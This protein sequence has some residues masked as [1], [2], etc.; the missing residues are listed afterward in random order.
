MVMSFK[1]QFDC[2]LNLKGCSCLPK[3][4][5]VDDNEFNTIPVIQWLKNNFKVEV[6]SASD[7]KEALDNY[8]RLLKNTESCKCIFRAYRLILM[9]ISMPIMPG[10]E[11]SQRIL[12]IMPTI[13]GST[14]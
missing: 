10:D 5:I 8:E 11:A 14:E 9:D 7:G 4:M 3:V 2:M 12:K 1:T 6:H 13:E